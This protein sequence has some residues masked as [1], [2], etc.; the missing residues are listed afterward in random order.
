MK[1]WSVLFLV[2]A[3]L[4]FILSVIGLAGGIAPFIACLVSALSFMFFHKLCSCVSTILDNQKNILDNQK[5]LL[6]MI[7]NL[8][9]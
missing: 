4:M 8:T 6:I 9:E 3:I 5:K 1:N 2:L 7:D